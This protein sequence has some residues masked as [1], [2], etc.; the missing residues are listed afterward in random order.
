MI[1]R[2]VGSILGFAGIALVAAIL[3]SDLENVE[4]TLTSL[5]DSASYLAYWYSASNGAGSTWSVQDLILNVEATSGTPATLPATGAFFNATTFSGATASPTPFA[6]VGPISPGGWEAILDHSAELTWAAP[7]EGMIALDSLPPDS[8]M[9]GFGIRSSYLPGLSTVYARP[10][11]QAC[12]SVYDTVTLENPEQSDFE[13][14]AHAVVPRYKPEEITIG[15]LQ[16]QAAAVCSDPLWIDDGPTCSAVADSLERVEDFL[17]VYNYPGAKNLIANTQAILDAE[18]EPS[19]AIEDNAYW[20]LDTNLTQL[21]GNLPD[22]DFSHIYL[23]AGGPANTTVSFNISVTAGVKT[24]R[25][26]HEIEAEE[27]GVDPLGSSCEEVWRLGINHA[28]V[29]DVSIWV[30]SVTAGM[31]VN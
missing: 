3:P 12:C 7:S 5:D 30:E 21:E 19:G 20:L 2:K 23:C 9:T 24:I 16:S 22:L 31:E 28:A 29:A 25:P 1:T 11:W 4:L 15:I 17:D 10:T 26:P 8:T 27:L 6:E 13:V 14:A 18:R